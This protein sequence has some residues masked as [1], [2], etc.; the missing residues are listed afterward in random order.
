[1]NI[2]RTPNGVRRLWEG[3]ALTEREEAR[4]E[5]FTPREIEESNRRVKGLVGQDKWV[6]LCDVRRPLWL[7]ETGQE[8]RCF[9]STPSELLDV[10][11]EEKE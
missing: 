4:K 11:A 3:E 5:L 7:E 2:Q 8:E 9:N 10:T 1:M 6:K